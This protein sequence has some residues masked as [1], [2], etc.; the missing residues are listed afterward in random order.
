MRVGA[1]SLGLFGGLACAIFDNLGP[2]LSGWIWDTSD[3]TTLPYL[4]SLPVTSY[5]CFFLF[6][7]VFAFLT[8]MICWDCVAGGE[9]SAP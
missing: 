5:H 8:R 6:T 3:L 4:S 1:V 2:M 7:G 9:Q